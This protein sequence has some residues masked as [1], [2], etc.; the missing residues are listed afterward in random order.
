MR[1]MVLAGV[2]LMIVTAAPAAAGGWWSSIQ[3]RS[4]FVGV[5]EKL[6]IR[7]EAFFTSLDDADA[8][9]GTAYYAYLVRGGY[10]RALLRHAMTKAEPLRWWAAADDATLI[11][12]GR[13]RWS[14]PMGNVGT[15]RATVRIPEVPAGRYH[16]MLC[17]AGCMHPFG[18]TIPAV[19]HV[20]ADPVAARAMRAAERLER[21]V[22]GH[23]HPPGPQVRHAQAAAHRA[24]SR[25]DNVRAALNELTERVQ[26]LEAEQQ[27]AP[28][29]TRSFTGPVL[30]GGLLLAVAALWALRRVARTR[31]AVGQPV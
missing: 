28:P 10:D 31:R 13:I 27:S 20:T 7:S 9:K 1:R 23:G 4:T 14:L 24:T 16:L 6:T 30:A 25:A 22:A 26:R 2:V 21:R 5:G 17:D 29:A 18:H 3:L 15:A 12:L 19:L 11:R 8:A